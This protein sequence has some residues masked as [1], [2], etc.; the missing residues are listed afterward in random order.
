MGVGCAVARI[1]LR[2][3]NVCTQKNAR[4]SAPF[5]R[6]GKC[7][8]VCLQETSRSH[9]DR[10]QCSRLATKNHENALDQG[11]GGIFLKDRQ[12]MQGKSTKVQ[13]KGSYLINASLN[14]AIR[15]L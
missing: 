3:L 2:F 5:V 1:H 8:F 14:P 9:N 15:R 6:P 11:R 4:A 12:R 13:A 7:S 10:R